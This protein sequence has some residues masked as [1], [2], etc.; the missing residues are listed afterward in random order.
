MI[1]WG[2]SSL[3]SLSFVTGCSVTFSLALTAPIVKMASSTT[4]IINKLLNFIF[5]TIVNI[6]LI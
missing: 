3:T 5:I 2:M 1:W 6:F 4:D